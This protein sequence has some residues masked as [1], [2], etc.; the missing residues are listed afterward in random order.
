MRFAT[1]WAPEVSALSIEYVIIAGVSPHV[2][3]QC[4]H[5]KAQDKSSKVFV[6]LKKI[7]VCSIYVKLAF[8][9]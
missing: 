7:E 6:A 1:F 9:Y 8:Y 4:L 3:S 5:S 2:C